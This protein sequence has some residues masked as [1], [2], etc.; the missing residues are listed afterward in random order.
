[1]TKD[2]KPEKQTTPA[3]AKANGKRKIKNDVVP[4]EQLK[5]PVEVIETDDSVQIPPATNGVVSKKKK[6]T[7]EDNNNNNNEKEDESSLYQIPMSRVSR[8]IKSEDPNIRIT[9]EAVYVINKASE[10]FLQVFTTEAYANA[11]LDHKK[12]ID[13]KHL[14]L[15]V[16]KRRRF[17]FLSDFVPEKLKAEEA[18]AES[19]IEN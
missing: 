8:I 4:E 5:V 15:A 2:P 7:K 1:M 18:L 17:D 6:I 16:G 13:Y 19:Q 3:P 10:K 11:F 14:S 12:H 9:Q